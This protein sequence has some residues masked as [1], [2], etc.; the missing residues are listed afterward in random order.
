MK[1]LSRLKGKEFL[2]DRFACQQVFEGIYFLLGVEAIFNVD[3]NLCMIFADVNLRNGRGM[4]VLH[5]AAW[6]MEP[7][8]LG[9]LIAKGARLKEYTP[10][11]QRALDICKRLV[12]KSQC[13]GDEYQ[14]DNLC[15]E[16][17][18]EA[19]NNVA[20]KIPSSAVAMMALPSTEENLMSTLLY[21]ENRGI[22]S[23]MCHILP[24]VLFSS[25]HADHYCT[26]QFS[27]SHALEARPVYC[28]I[29]FF[30]VCCLQCH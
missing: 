23:P 13:K 18:K 16:I 20:T 25:I 4:T 6:R 15:I 30:L 2:V 10:D 7:Q 9:N 27:S 11:N 17:L 21:L 1:S 19:E 22:L 26:G 24:C 3:D 12:K 28:L 8:A 29:L 5:V 14:K